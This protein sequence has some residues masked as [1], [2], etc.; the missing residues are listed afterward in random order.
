MDTQLL[1]IQ[2]SNEIHFKDIPLLRGGFIQMMEREAGNVNLLFH[3]HVKDG[4]RWSYPLVQYK[5]IDGKAAVVCIGE[6]I[7]AIKEFF[8][9]TNRMWS[10][11]GKE[12]VLQIQDVRMSSFDLET[13]TEPVRCRIRHWIPLNSANYNKYI[14]TESLAER[15]GLLENILSAN[16][17]SMAKGLGK[18]IE[19]KVACSITDLSEPELIESKSVKMMTFDAGFKTNVPLPQYIGLGKHASIGYGMIIYPYSI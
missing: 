11:H 14:Q 12:Q 4:F 18:R 10:L 6:G 8:S 1:T 5:E 3:N 17:L 13:V 19:S 2:F 9:T 16:I 15:I 7:E